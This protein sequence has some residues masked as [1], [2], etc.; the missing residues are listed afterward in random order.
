MRVSVRRTPRARRAGAACSPPETGEHADATAGT[1]AERRARARSRRRWSASSTGRPQPGA[2]PFVEEG[3]TVA[4]GQTLCI[5]EAMK[6][7]NEIKADAAGSRPLDPRR[8]RRAGRVRAAAVRARAGRPAARSTRSDV[9]RVLVANRGEIAV[10]VIRALHE[11]GIE[12][13]AV[14]STADRDSLHVRLA[15]RAVCIGPPQAAESYLRIPSIIAAATTTGCEAVHPGYG[16]LSENP[17][18]VEACADNDLVFVGPPRGR[19]GADGRQG[20][21]RRREMRD[22]GRAR[23]SRAPRGRRRSTRRAPPPTRSA[24]R[25]CSRRRPGGGGKGMRLVEDRERA[26]D[27]YGDGARSRRRRR[28]ATA[29]STSRRRVVAGA[30]RRD[31]G[32]L[33]RAGRRAD[34]R[35]ARVLDPAPPPEA[36]RGVAVARARRPRRARRWS[37]PPSAPAARSATATPAP[38][39]SCSAP[40]GAFYFIELNARLQVEHPVT[41]LVHRASTSS[42]SSSGS[43]PASRSRRPAARR[44]RGH[45]IEVRLNAEDPA[46]DFAPAPGRIERFRPPL[47][48]GVRLDTF[49]E[50]GFVVPPYYDSLLG[51]ADRLGRRRGRTAID[52]HAARARGARDRGRADDARAGARDPA[53]RGV[54]ER[55]LLDETSSPRPRSG[56]RRWWARERAARLSGPEGS[57]TMTPVRAH[58]SSSSARG[59][60]RRRRARAPAAAQRRRRG[61]GSRAR[62]VELGAAH[63]EPLP[64]VAR[65]V[66]ERCGRRSTQIV[67][68]RGRARGRRGRGARA[69]GGPPRRAADGA[70]PALPVGRHRPA[71]SAS[72]YEGEVDDVRARAR[73]GASSREHERARRADHRRRRRA[74]PPTG[75]ARSSATSCGS[76]SSSSTAARCRSRSRST[77]RSRW[78]SATPPRTPAG[79]STASSGKIVEGGE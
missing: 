16:F 44:A 17:A 52:A 26:R 38:S 29:A 61:S 36:D 53:Q 75:S 6:L 31:P 39:S 5:L 28:S 23:S 13:V 41:E 10:R 11:I 48:P 21:R 25:C 73:R 43:P 34:A 35:R 55:P 60:E 70:V 63:G 46:R 50:E 32:A 40:T 37:P 12:A 58:A 64:A 47:G 51:E 71:S 78:R 8:Q 18:F 66:Q 30:P 49:V 20:R 3:D 79:S 33:R 69:D 2:A 19:D 1:A 57:I 15:D 76:R 54:R 56:C 65:A 72:L 14:Y 68:A 62:S 42:A 27:A 74:G 67:R 22:A 24:T 4:P 9:P 7:M 77:R 59:R 45:A